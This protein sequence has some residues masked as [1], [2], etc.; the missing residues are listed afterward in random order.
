M[1]F[2]KLVE[3]GPRD[4]LQN[5]PTI[6]PANIKIEFINR[7]SETGLSVIEVT[8][9][10][11]PQWIPQLADHEEVFQKITKKNTISYPVLVP[12][13]QGFENALVLGVKNI[14][15]FTTPSETFCKKNTNCSVAESMKNIA[16][17]LELAKKNNITVR[18]YLSCVLGCPY[19]GDISP[20]KVADCA[21]KLIQLGCNEISLGDTIGTGTIPKTK[22][23][24]EAVS[25]KIPLE[26]MA[27]HFHDTYGQAL[28]N[29][30]AALECG[31][32]IIDSSVGGLGG[33][34][35]AKNATGNV[36][37][38]DVL[39]ML[40]GLGIKTQVDLEKIKEVKQF[41][42]KYSGSR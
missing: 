26:K 7:L 5:E 27:V 8:S 2:V 36:A 24:I 21:E 15:V 39:Y 14:A 17:I 22:K 1:T 13:Q 9:F 37:T 42:Q 4:G 40:N 11:S 29:I 18:G 32:H 30:Y 33:C 3:V 10:V 28:V 31:V 35:Y 38:E 19:E 34:P 23:L 16:I 6:I 41:I 25:Q 12:N 20:E